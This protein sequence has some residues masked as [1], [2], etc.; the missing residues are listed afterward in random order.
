MIAGL[1]WSQQ[2]EAPE[3]VIVTPAAVTA[4]PPSSPD[5]GAFAALS[6][7]AGEGVVSEP[8][9]GL[10]AMGGVGDGEVS[11]AISTRLRGRRASMPPPKT[12][13]KPPTSE[14]S[15]TMATVRG[16]NC[17][18]TTGAF[19]PRVALEGVV[20]PVLGEFATQ[21]AQNSGAGMKSADSSLRIS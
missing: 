1:F 9:S 15:A 11:G 12:V 8:P 7:S 16:E 20:G 19:I 21:P 2:R 14:A 10:S 17:S 18:L 5:G 6:G 13:T 3:G 4:A